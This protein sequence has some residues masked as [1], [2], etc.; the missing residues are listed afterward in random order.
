M[1]QI[2]TCISV[3]PCIDRQDRTSDKKLT[4]IQNSPTNRNKDILFYIILYTSYNIWYTY[5]KALYN[6]NYIVIKNSM[7]YPL[8]WQS[9]AWHRHS[10][11]QT[12]LDWKMR[13]IITFLRA[14]R[15]KIALIFR[16]AANN[17]ILLTLCFIASSTKAKDVWPK[18]QFWNKK[19]SWKKFHISAAMWG[20]LRLYLY[21]EGEG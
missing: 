8:D 12:W 20:Y 13:A 16:K 7:Q 21:S 2:C 11:N 4:H 19:G 6:I 3:T 15:A 9:T 14:I 10:F 18:F 17:D 5:Y 1:V